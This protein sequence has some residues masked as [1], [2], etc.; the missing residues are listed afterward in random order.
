MLPGARGFTAQVSNSFVAFSLFFLML[1]V[2]FFQDGM[3]WHVAGRDASRSA[4]K[5]S[6]D[7]GTPSLFLALNAVDH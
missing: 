3:Y 5:Q 4:A 7:P 6:F 2:V 1:M